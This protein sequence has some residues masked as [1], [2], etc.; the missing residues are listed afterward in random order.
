LASIC[1]N[2]PNDGAEPRFAAEAIT[3]L[4]TLSA[5]RD[6]ARLTA[7]DVLPLVAQR[8]ESGAHRF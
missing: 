5:L 8:S 1:F 6:E 7:A 3:P 4:T 2:S